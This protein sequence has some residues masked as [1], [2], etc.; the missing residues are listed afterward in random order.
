VRSRS[1]FGPV[2]AVKV[3]SVRIVTPAAVISSMRTVGV[4]AGTKS[5]SYAGRGTMGGRNSKPGVPPL[6]S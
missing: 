6:R 5:P 2:V 4:T 3:A 1:W